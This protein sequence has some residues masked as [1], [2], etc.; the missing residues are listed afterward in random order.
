VTRRR[1]DAELVRRG[2]VASRAEA[3]EAVRAGLVTVAGSPAVKVA[4]LVSGDAA[5]R[6]AGPARRYV[7]RGGD[8]LRAGLDR[9]A[10]DPAGADC[11]DAGASTGGFTDCLLKAGATRVIAVDVGYGQLA[12]ELR[13]DPRVSVVDR[14]NVRLLSREM[15][16]FAPSLVVA[17]LSFISL[18]TV[19]GTLVDVATHDAIHLVLV[20]P[21]FEAGPGD[22]RRG[23]VV[24]DP[25]VW[26]RVLEEVVDAFE[27]AG[28]TPRSAMAS[29]VLGPAGNVEFLLLA[30]ARL[31]AA[32]GLDLDAAV[33]EGEEV[34]EG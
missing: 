24:R 13:N 27:E 32:P 18:R 16:P 34:R 11:L 21:Q 9:F 22:V 30:G 3:Q 33:A 25:A 1:L 17:D 5:V 8:K 12:W 23:G 20:K 28:A 2:L 14:T 6:L 7:S 29:P 19:I 26:H 31:V 10:L 4:T 15:L